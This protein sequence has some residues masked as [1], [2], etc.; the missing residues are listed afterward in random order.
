LDE[1]ILRE[2]VWI[3]FGWFECNDVPLYL[4]RRSRLSLPPRKGLFV[5]YYTLKVAEDLRDIV[6]NIVVSRKKRKKI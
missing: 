2:D 4:T 5:D 1:S 6:N 3:R